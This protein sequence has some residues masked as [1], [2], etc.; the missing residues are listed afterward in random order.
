MS[1]CPYC[2]SEKTQESTD[3][4]GFKCLDCNGKWNPDL[5]WIHD[6]MK[7]FFS[8]LGSIYQRLSEQEKKEID[9]MF[10][11]ATGKYK[12]SVKVQDI[13]PKSSMILLLIALEEMSEVIARALS[14]VLPS[15]YN[16]SH[17]V[18]LT[19]HFRKLP[20]DEKIYLA[21]DISG[22]YEIAR[23]R[24][25]Y[26]YRSIIFVRKIDLTCQKR[27]KMVIK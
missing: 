3:I 14:T 20:K 23:N 18:K 1:K 11:S 22:P 7:Y 4:Q 16:K 13:D 15:S 10:H 24:P 6:G 17:E 27:H 25:N 21:L 8:N 26:E 2:K 5:L 19:P 12:A 9:E